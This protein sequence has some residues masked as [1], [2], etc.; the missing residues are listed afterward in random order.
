[1]LYPHNNRID[2]I[3]DSYDTEK[4]Y[5]IQTQCVCRF[6]SDLHQQGRRCLNKDRIPILCYH[7]VL[8]HPDRYQ[9]TRIKCNF[10]FKMTTLFFVNNDIWSSYLYIKNNDEG[11]Y[12][13][14]NFNIRGSFCR[15]VMIYSMI[16]GYGL[17]NN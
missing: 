5:P 4:I 17:L 14:F 13:L 1:M 11:V 3:H 12:K 15:P 7:L 16:N 10:F 8:D 2:T 9:S 6:L